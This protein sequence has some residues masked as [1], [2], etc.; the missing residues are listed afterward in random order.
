[1][2]TGNFDSIR[3]YRYMWTCKFQIRNKKFRIQKYPNTRTDGPEF[4][5]DIV[6]VIVVVVV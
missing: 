4:E 1:M 6:V 2:W 3:L 5:E